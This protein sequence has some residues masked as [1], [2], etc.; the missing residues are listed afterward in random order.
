[1]DVIVRANME[2]FREVT[3][4]CEALKEIWAE[5][6]EQARNEGMEIGYVKGMIETGKKLGVSWEKVFELVQ[7]KFSMTSEDAEANMK[8]YW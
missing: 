3:N 6:F 1:M 7:E 8:L 2:K 5:D 4:M